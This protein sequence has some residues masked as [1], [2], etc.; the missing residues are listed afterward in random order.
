MPSL[1]QYTT[2]AA[3]SQIVAIDPADASNQIIDLAESMIDAYVSDF[4]EGNFSKSYKGS[5]R[6]EPSQVNF[7]AT[8]LTINSGGSN[9]VDYF[10][11]TVIEL[12][13]GANKGLLIPVISSVNNVL[14]FESVTGLTGQIACRIYQLGKFPMS[15]YFI[16]YKSIP[17]EVV[18]A[19][20]YQV[21][22]LLEQ[23]Q[24]IYQTA[25]K[26]ESIGENYSYTNEDS[27]GDTLLRRI[28]P[29]ARD[30]LEAAGYTAQTI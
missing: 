27:S 24:R 14:T 11:Y 1:R 15:S 20:A 21:Q 6:L 7:T 10:S 4:Y 8:T 19:V 9:T 3:I 28:A 29:L 25:K 23:G 12:L 18:E 2:A 13:S 17:R 5:L 26:S 30:I 22:F 16:T